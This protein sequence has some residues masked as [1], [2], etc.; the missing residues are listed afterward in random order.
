MLE[1]INIILFHYINQYAGVN[2]STDFIAVL[3]AQYMPV[4]FILVLAYLWIQN[5]NKY[6]NI[7]LYGI[8]ASINWPCD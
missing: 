2:P 3:M 6:R 7:V 5:G 8:Y 4:V 1:Q